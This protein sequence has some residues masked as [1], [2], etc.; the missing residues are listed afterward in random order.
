M[1]SS[2]SCSSESESSFISY[3]SSFC[4]AMSNSESDDSLYEIPK[5]ET[6]RTS[7]LLADVIALPVF[8]GNSHCTLAE[9]SDALHVGCLFQIDRFMIA[10][11]HDDLIRGNFAWRCCPAGDY[12]SVSYILQVLSC[13]LFLIS[14]ISFPRYQVM[15]RT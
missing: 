9:V 7:L 1:P 8:L 14:M 3:S 5:E 2:Y 4:G 13:L 11:E 15:S 6:E 10:G 12:F